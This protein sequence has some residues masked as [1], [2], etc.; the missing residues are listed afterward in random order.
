MKFYFN[1]LFLTIIN[2]RQYIVQLPL[3]RLIT[4][5]FGGLNNHQIIECHE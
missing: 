3:K 2:I 1:K 5:T 4:Y